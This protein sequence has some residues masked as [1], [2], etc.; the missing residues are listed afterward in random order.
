MAA[1]HVIFNL[2]TGAAALLILPLILMLIIWLQQS[3]GMES[4]PATFLALFHTIFNVL[5]I[6]LLWPFTERLVRY[7]KTLF[8]AAEEDEARPKY[9]DKT[10]SF[11]GDYINTC[12]A[13]ERGKQL[14]QKLNIKIAVSNYQGFWRSY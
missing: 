14:I 10:L 4:G 8:R 9:L 5:G 3:A 1:G 11:R 13:T 12:M 7:L 2:I 6:A